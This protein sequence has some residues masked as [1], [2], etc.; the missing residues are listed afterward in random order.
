MRV[1]ARV[2][3]PVEA[4]S[5]GVKGVALPKVL[6]QTAERW[7]PEAMYFAAFD[8]SRTAYIVVDLP[9]ESDIPRFAE[10]FF[11]EPFFMELNAKLDV[12][13][14][15]TIEDVQGGLAPLD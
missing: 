3:I 4:G 6:H 2:S 11:I 9:Q 15:M 10:P 13:P 12:A 8:G 1:M 14:L 5:E 7:R